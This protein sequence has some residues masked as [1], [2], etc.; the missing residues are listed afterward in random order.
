MLAGLG[1]ACCV[2]GCFFVAE[3]RCV[4]TRR[5]L[6]AEAVPESNSR[7][8]PHVAW[9][10]LFSWSLATAIAGQ[11]RMCLRSQAADVVACLLLAE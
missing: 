9:I 4:S 5:N 11:C 10:F 8:A 6:S 7:S 3:M 2:P 1:K